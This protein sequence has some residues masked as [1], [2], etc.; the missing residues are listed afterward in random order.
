VGFFSDLFG[1]KGTVDV[2]LT[3]KGVPPGIKER[4]KLGFV[5]VKKGAP[6]PR[7]PGE[8][9]RWTGFSDYFSVTKRLP[10]GF[11]QV[12][13]VMEP[14]IPDDAGKMK[15]DAS[16]AIP[17]WPLAEAFEITVEGK[18]SIKLEVAF[19]RAALS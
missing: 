1:P 9:C 6:P 11:W 19:P 12:T 18:T 14:I 4:H 15:K 16:R 3:I 2:V 10:P 7:S 13:L 17:F 8:D 5:P